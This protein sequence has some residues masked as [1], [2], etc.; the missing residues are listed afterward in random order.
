MQQA[1]LRAGVH[2][3]LQRVVVRPGDVEATGHSHAA[4]GAVHPARIRASRRLR[5]LGHDPTA[6]SS[7]AETGI[8]RHVPDGGES[9]DIRSIQSSV[10][11]DT[12]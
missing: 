9:G 3:D 5:H 11:S 8:R 10:T 7:T 1:R 6:A 2:V 4:A 12:Q